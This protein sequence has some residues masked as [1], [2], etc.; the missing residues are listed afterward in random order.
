MHIILYL[1]NWLLK[2]LGSGSAKAMTGFKLRL[3]HRS[4]PVYS[5]IL[6]ALVG[7]VCPMGAFCNEVRSLV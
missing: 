7:A 3:L 4:V 2:F 6:G 1:N 5:P